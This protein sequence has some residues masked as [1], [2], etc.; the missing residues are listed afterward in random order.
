M[1]NDKSRDQDALNVQSPLSANT[2]AQVAMGSS[3]GVNELLFTRSSVLIMP[4]GLGDDSEHYGAIFGCGPVHR[5]SMASPIPGVLHQLGPLYI[6]L[7]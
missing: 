4:V 7:C 2:C 6:D 1:H 3:F 5:P